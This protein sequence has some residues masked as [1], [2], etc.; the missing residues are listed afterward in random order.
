MGGGLDVVDLATGLIYY[1][2]FLFSTT[3][4]EAAHAWAAMR[5]GDLTA[6]HGGQV[7]LDPIPHIRREPFGMVVLPLLGVLIS[8]WPFGYASAPYDPKWALAHPRRAALMA[9]AGPAS[10]TLLVIASGLALLAGTMAGVFY[11]P[12]SVRFG[13]IAASTLGGVW[14]VLALVLG[15]IFS[16]N[17]LL[18]LFNLLPF[19]PLDGSGAMPLVLSAEASRKYQEFM[20]SN[21]MFSLIGL[22]AAWKLFGFIFTPIFTLAVSALY[23]GVSYH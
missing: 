16:L 5:G 17:L 18:A 21:P 8:G 22:F 7:S 23:P 10:N 19:P 1:A 12:E 15:I 13:H 11:A 9:L 3:L 14:P 4:H 2:V 6:Y 20:W